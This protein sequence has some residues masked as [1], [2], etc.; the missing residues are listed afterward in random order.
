MEPA[1]GILQDQN[2]QVCKYFEDFL[3]V[4]TYFADVLEVC[5]YLADFLEVCR[6]SQIF[7]K[8]VGI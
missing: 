5:T 8:S 2:A 4:C 6:F 7:S 1:S 3:E